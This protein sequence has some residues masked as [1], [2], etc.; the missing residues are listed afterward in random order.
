MGLRE[1]SWGFPPPSCT[2]CPPALHQQLPPGRLRGRS[3]R[4][5]G[6]GMLPAPSPAA[7]WPVLFSLF[8][9]IPLGAP[10]QG[11]LT[12]VPIEASAPARTLSPEVLAATIR[13]TTDGQRLEEKRG[14]LSTRVNGACS[15]VHG[16]VTVCAP[17]CTVTPRGMW[18]P[19]GTTDTLIGSCALQHHCY[20]GSRP[21]SGPRDRPERNGQLRHEEGGWGHIPSAPLP[22]PT[23]HPHRRLLG[24]GGL[25]RQ[26]VD[27][28]V[29]LVWVWKLF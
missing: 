2:T 14:P 17:V 7:P 10:R 21:M 26:C 28:L 3:C 1:L 5:R 6:Q 23:W 13:T 12:S 4:S 8:S 22:V 9:A 20:V 24:H 11:L 27:C 15:G 18:Q 19:S 16:D 25:Q 29:N